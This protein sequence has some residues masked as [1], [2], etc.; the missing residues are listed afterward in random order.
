MHRLLPLL[1]LAA[2]ATAQTSEPDALDPRG[3]FPLAVGNEWEYE[4]VF[5]SP[6][7]PNTP[8]DVT[9]TTYI[10]YRIVGAGAGPEQD[11]YVLVHEE[12]A[13]TGT[14]SSRDTTL[15][16]YDEATASVLG[17]VQYTDGTPTERPTPWFASC[18]DMTQ[19]SDDC[20]WSW[21][22]ASSDN[23][24]FWSLPDFLG[25]TD[26]L[27]IRSFENIGGA[28]AVAV[29]GFGFAGGGSFS[30]GCSMFCWSLGWTV[31]YARVD[32]QVYGAHAIATESSRPEAARLAVYPNPAHDAV[33][34][35][36]PSQPGATVVV[37][38]VRGRAVRTATVPAG[39]TL[40]LDVRA[41]PAG[42]YLVRAG[43]R[44][45]RLVVR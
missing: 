43:E 30:D 24:D 38:D 26:D 8:Q 44:V 25:D 33:T 23:A 6:A 27:T 3:Y 35:E 2:T 13:E 16:R 29:H 5:F 20:S 28:G 1:L 31:T 42:V 34:V 39:G 45:G 32:G 36:A 11:R 17:L 21:S 40:R 9:V 7:G 12:Y 41:L 14:L 22:S 10:R 19:G 18:L 15:V 37:Y 4:E